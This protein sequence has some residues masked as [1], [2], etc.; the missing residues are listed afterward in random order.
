MNP[1]SPEQRIPLGYE[2]STLSTSS[3]LVWKASYALPDSDDNVIDFDFGL[4]ENVPIYSGFMKTSEMEP[5]HSLFILKENGDVHV[6]YP[7]LNHAAAKSRDDEFYI[8]NNYD[9]YFR[10][11]V[12]LSDPLPV[13]PPTSA[14]DN[15][16]IEAC[17]IICL[18]SDPCVIGIG[19]SNGTV[20][21]SLVIR[22]DDDDDDDG[23]DE[24]TFPLK[25]C[26]FVFEMIDLNL[27]NL[28]EL[29]G[30]GNELRL[31]PGTTQGRRLD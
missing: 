21:H 4:V 27:T 5:I 13:H 18:K 14:E 20:S 1:S 15:Y 3:S 12:F 23:G 26:R 9:V 11:P 7:R 16:E 6:M 30:N 31:H 28:D 2:E 19:L 22:Q 29:T 8:I 24:K 25:K 10:C 17:S